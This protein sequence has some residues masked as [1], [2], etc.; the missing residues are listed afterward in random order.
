MPTNT[1]E[2]QLETILVSYLRDQHGYE[3]GVSTTITK[4]MRSTPSV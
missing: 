3:E 2:K 1:S 4:T